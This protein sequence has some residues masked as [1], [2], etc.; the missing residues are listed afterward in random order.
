MQVRV[1]VNAASLSRAIE[2]AKRKEMALA[3]AKLNNA[4]RWGQRVV[5]SEVS[6]YIDKPV[7]F[8]INAFGYKT[9]RMGNPV[10]S[11]YIK[12]I[13]AAYLASTI[14]GGFLFKQKPMPTYSTRDRFGNLP[15][16]SVRR[17]ELQI[18]KGKRIRFKKGEESGALVSVKNSRGDV[19][20][21]IVRG[22]FGWGGTISWLW[23]WSERGSY[24]KPRF[25]FYNIVR[26][27]VVK[28]MREY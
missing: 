15:R 17:V 22:K 19:V 7:P 6:N 12:D 23:S 13:Q 24:R 4:A 11:V 25:P 1:S 14:K 9:A 16:G 8:T 5:R 18:S 20:A 26:M 27:A 10:A 21:G 2:S 28:A 3:V